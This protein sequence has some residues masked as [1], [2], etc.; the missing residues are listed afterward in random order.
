MI[1]SLAS[2]FIIPKTLVFSLS[3]H[4]FVPSIN[5]LV[6]IALALIFFVLD[7]YL[8]CFKQTSCINFKN[9][10]SATIKR[11]ILFVFAVVI[12]SLGILLI[13]SLLCGGI[14]LVLYLL[15]N[16][17]FAFSSIKIIVSAIS[18]ILLIAALPFIFSLF[19]HYAYGDEKISKLTKSSIK[20]G[21]KKYLRYL[22]VSVIFYFAI[23]L[24]VYF[25]TSF[26]NLGLIISFIVVVI[27][28]FFVFYFS[29]KVYLNKK[30]IDI[31]H[32][33]SSNTSQIVNKDL[34]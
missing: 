19:W 13:L 15:L 24:S 20:I 23:S 6:L 31:P 9:Y 30:I 32:K 18:S 22:V 25:V 8:F 29:E 1:I 7:I 10:D 33:S 2:V 34:R 5:F 21:G 26:A 14:S 16:S 28:S 11:N 12:V 17:L 4:I 27:A 3:T